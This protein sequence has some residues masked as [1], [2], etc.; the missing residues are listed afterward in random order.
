MLNL[1]LISKILGSLLCL[2]AIMMAVCLAVTLCYGGSDTLAFVLSI[3][4]TA[5]VGLL[6]RRRP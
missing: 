6:F 3:A 5:A 2:E 1:K 4:I